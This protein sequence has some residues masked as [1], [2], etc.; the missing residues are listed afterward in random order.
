MV[1]LRRLAQ[2]DI[3]RW[4]IHSLGAATVG[5]L[6]LLFWCASRHIQQQ[7]A[8]LEIEHRAASTLLL[9]A[10][11]VHEAHA[12]LTRELD[13]SLQQQRACQLRDQTPVDEAELMA[14]ISQLTEK[15]HMSLKNFRPIHSDGSRLDVHVSLTGSYANLCQFLDS[16]HTLPWLLQ[17][18]E[19]DLVA[20][21]RAQDQ[22]AVELK[23]QSICNPS[24]SEG[25]STVAFQ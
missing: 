24:E 15:Y 16:L 13:R 18:V 22:C 14:L 10:A 8:R 7:H 21:T 4:S 17:I 11:D 9:G 1:A 12:R 23:M 5:L 6:V 3:R 25:R 20:P 2:I 19:L